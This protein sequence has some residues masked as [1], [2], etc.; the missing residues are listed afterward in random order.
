VR[1]ARRH[2]LTGVDAS[3]RQAE[4]AGMNVPTGEFA[5]GDILALE[6][7]AGTFGAVTAF[8]SF[9]HLPRERL[10]EMF[11]L[12]H[13]WL[14]ESG[15][16]LCCMETEDTPGMVADWLGA[17][18]YFSSYEPDTSRRLLGEAGFDILR[19]EIEAQSEEGREVSCLWLL[20][21]KR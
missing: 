2:R 6:Y 11:R 1:I 20:A 8:Y 10:P 9:D 12:I 19:D 15:L 18:M 7:P 16:L 4:L 5:T 13:G 17:P 14:A 3:A 21:R